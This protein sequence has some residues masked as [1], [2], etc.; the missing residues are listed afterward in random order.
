MSKAL[1]KLGTLDCIHIAY[2]LPIG[3][4][5]CIICVVLDEIN[6]VEYAAYRT[7]MKIRTIQKVCWRKCVCV[8]VC[9]CVRVCVCVFVCCT[10]LCCHLQLC[11]P[12]IH[13]C[14]VHV[15]K[16]HA[17]VEAWGQ[18]GLGDDQNVTVTTPAECEA[19]LQTVFTLSKGDRPSDILDTDRAT[20][21]TLS[22]LLGLVDR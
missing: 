13:T 3:Y 6:N 12:H 10:Y 14:T 16:K 7:A 15:V 17:L 2:C 20:Q 18:H 8:C 1:H 5:I 19:V 11:L 4:V 22:W 21:I 9:A